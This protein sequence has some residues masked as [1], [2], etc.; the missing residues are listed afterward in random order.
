LKLKRIALFASVILLTFVSL[1]V[2]LNMYKGS[3][4]ATAEVFQLGIETVVLNGVGSTTVGDYPDPLPEG[5]Y[6]R[7]IVLAYT[8]IGTQIW[9]KNILPSFAQYWEEKTGEKVKFTTGWATLGMDSVAT[10]VYGKPVQ[11]MVLSSNDNGLS[12][13]FSETKWQ[14]TKHKGII[15]SYPY[16]FVVRKGNPKNILTYADLTRPDVQ[17][18]HIDP[19]GT[20]GGM[21][22]IYGL[23]A[24]ALK[25]SEEKTGKKDHMAA[26]EYLR[27]VEE[28]AILGFGGPGATA[29]FE[30]GVGDVLILLEA[31]AKALAERNPSCEVVV[32]PNTFMTSLRVYKMKKNISKKDEELIDAFIDFLFS[33]QSQEAFARAG[34]R[35]SDPE[36]MAR[37]PEFPSLPGVLD[38]QY[39]GEPTKIKKDLVLG[40][41][42]DIK[43]STK[44]DHQR[45]KLKKLPP[46]KIPD[47]SGLPTQQALPEE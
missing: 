11:V 41:W 37:H 32:P 20:H 36:I 44:P 2:Y 4:V 10:H 38:M 1:V 43:N 22:N 16:F 42:L 14:N 24:A 45:I 3:A 47:Q 29:L 12:R 9:F 40:K 17:V 21:T 26:E 46:G 28:K 19:L 6:D 35:P 30:R 7:E 33:E 18:V 8:C 39:L 5:V 15:Y 27:Q 25:E 34:F 23:Y 13:G 31:R